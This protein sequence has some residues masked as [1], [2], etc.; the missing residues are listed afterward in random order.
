MHQRRCHELIAPIEVAPGGRLRGDRAAVAREAPLDGKFLMRSSDP[1]LSHEDT[2]LGYKQLLQ[3]ERGWRDM[4][5]TLD[6]RRVYHRNADRIR[7]RV[8]LCWLALLLVRVAETATPDTWRNVRSELDEMHL[9]RFRGPA[10]RIAQRTETSPQ[11]AAI[12]RALGAEEPPRLFQ[13]DP[14]TAA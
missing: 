9:G 7:A 10:G 1:T 14:A 8:V 2:A 13:L 11:Q 3:V 12:F 6:L 4:K 5:T